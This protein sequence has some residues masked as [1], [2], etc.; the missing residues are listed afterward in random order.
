MKS[1]TMLYILCGLMFLGFALPTQAY[2]DPG[3]GSFL[4][5]LV[6]A[7][8]L[9]GLFFIKSII[10]SVKLKLSSIFGEKKVKSDNRVENNEQQ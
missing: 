3:T 9:G 5:Q 6:I 7:G 8:A 4:F 2:I 1:S 10:R